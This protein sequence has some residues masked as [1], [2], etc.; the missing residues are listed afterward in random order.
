[1]IQEL[2]LKLMQAKSS[3]DILEYK[4]DMLELYQK[5]YED[6]SKQGLNI[7]NYEDIKN[8]HDLE[9]TMPAYY[10]NT[11]YK[12]CG[13]PFLKE[14]NPNTLEV[15]ELCII[16]YSLQICELLEQGFFNELSLCIYENPLLPD[17]VDHIEKINILRTEK[18]SQTL[19]FTLWDIFM[20]I[21]T[22][23]EDDTPDKNVI[24]LHYG[25]E[26]CFYISTEEYEEVLDMIY[27]NYNQSRYSSIIRRIVGIY[28]Q[29]F[30][31]MSYILEY[32]P[33][34]VKV[35]YEYFYEST[36]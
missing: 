22:I 36:L 7:V 9:R 26:D 16:F 35:G 18:Y 21:I 8:L 17:M 33:I 29:R 20:K 30:T 15:I 10:G 5:I 25:E 13:V 32:Q 23:G 28:R 19:F 4:P 11:F 14:H 27:K 31:K 6:L 12:D 24:V 1:M 2:L 3:E 34:F